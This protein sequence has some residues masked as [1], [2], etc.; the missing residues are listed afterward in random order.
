MV[1]RIENVLR[2][3]NNVKKGDLVV[4]YMPVCPVAVASMLAC[5]HI[6]AVHRY[7]NIGNLAKALDRPICLELLNLSGDWQHSFMFSVFHLT[8]TSRSIYGRVMVYKC[9]RFL[10]SQVPGFKHCIDQ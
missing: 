8:S 4:I 6:G 7:T 10:E 9:N 3:D 1:C 5:A 2:K